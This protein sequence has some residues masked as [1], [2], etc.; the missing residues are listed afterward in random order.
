MSGKLSG[1]SAIVTGS[2]K[3]I[4]AAIAKHL[5]AAGA[6][7]VVN[8]S[9][10]QSDADK[11]VTEIVAQGG[12]A[13]AVGA[14]V[15]KPEEIQRLFA[16]SAAAFGTLDVLV[17]NAGIYLGAPVGEITPEHF[18]KQYDLNVLGLILSAQEAL[19]HFGPDGGSIVNVSSVVA[20]LCPVGTAVYNSTK[21]AVDNLTRTFAKEL[22]PKRIRVN[23]VNPGPVETEGTH[24]AGFVGAFDQ[25]AA[26]TPLGR[27]GQPDDIASGVVFLASDDSRWMTGETLYLTGGL[28]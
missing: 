23:A 21:A 10:S 17:N 3:G 5:A 15:S 27:V 28:R 11:V 9:S 24:A 26:I 22:G 7:V 2:S 8:Y 1:K 6:K 12:T 19:K 14:N 20:T 25:F 4:G 18:H 13:I 16:E